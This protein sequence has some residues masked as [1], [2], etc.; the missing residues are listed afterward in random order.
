MIFTLIE[1]SLGGN[2]SPCSC[3]TEWRD[4]EIQ[5]TSWD[6]TKYEEIVAYISRIEYLGKIK[7]YN[8]DY[9]TLLINGLDTRG[10][11]ATSHIEFPAWVDEEPSNEEKTYNAYVDKFWDEVKARSDKAAE[12]Y[13]KEEKIKQEKEAAR[14]KQLQIQA[15]KAEEDRQKAEYERLKQKFGKSGD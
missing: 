15:N 2:I 8:Y 3:C 7:K 1:Y 11:D 5:V 14:Q 4:G 12:E 13:K 10:Y 6:D 9:Y